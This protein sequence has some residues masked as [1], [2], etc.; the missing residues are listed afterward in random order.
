MNEGRGGVDG[1]SGWVKQE[2][3]KKMEVGWHGCEGR[4]CYRAGKGWKRRCV[5]VGGWEELRWRGVEWMKRMLGEREQVG[6]KQ[7]RW[8]NAVEAEVNRGVQDAALGSGK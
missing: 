6:G 7:C 2:W 3:C 4:G 5:C 8:G 1:V